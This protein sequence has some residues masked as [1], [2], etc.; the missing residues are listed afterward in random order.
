MGTNILELVKTD[1][2]DTFEGFC[3]A[4]YSD[5][6]TKRQQLFDKIYDGKPCV[7]SVQELHYSESKANIFD[8]LSS[9]LTVEGICDKFD[10]M[11]DLLHEAGNK[12]SIDGLR[13]SYEVSQIEDNDAQQFSSYASCIELD[14][15]DK[16]YETC[17]NMMNKY[18]NQFALFSNP[19][20]EEVC[21]GIALDT[22]EQ[23]DACGFITVSAYQ[24]YNEFYRGLSE[25]L[26]EWMY[27]Q[28][29]ENLEALESDFSKTA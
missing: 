20:K 29:H 15:R 28:M 7:Q 4:I 12:S 10:D 24:V 26:G 13:F 8:P 2:K 22:K 1:H 5:Q 25:Q 6:M 3:D 14:A 17:L 11:I 16:S 18:D 27:T 21:H 9:E 19:Q 23:K